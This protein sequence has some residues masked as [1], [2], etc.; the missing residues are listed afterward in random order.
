MQLYKSIKEFKMTT[1]NWFHF[2]A[3]IFFFSFVLSG[4]TALAQTQKHY[5]NAKTPKGLREIFHYTGD[6]VP[7]LSSHRGGPEKNMPEN[8]TATFAN[9]LRY[10][11][12]TMEI[13]PRYTKDSVIIVHHDPT[14]DRTTTGHGKVSDFTYKELQ[15]LNLKDKEGNPTNYKIQTLREMLKWAKGKTILVLDKKD[16]PIEDRIKMVEDCKAESNAIVMA[17]NL[18]EAKLA[19]ELDKDIMM[20]V[21]INTPEKVLEFDQTG[22]P[23]KNVVVFVSHQMPEDTTVFDLIHQKGA[24]CILG[25]SRNL[26]R[27][28]IRGNVSDTGEIKNEYN[29]LFQAGADI[30]ETDIPVEV[31]NLVFDDVPIQPSKKKYFKISK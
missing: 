24:L 23:W 19:Y 6:R 26:D 17:Y 14:L 18:D 22:V 4:I 9:T 5:I 8:H 13:D 28:F 3:V 7:F 10:T 11:W 15:L 1:R 21:F 27:E 31:C 12:S 2:V 30:L 20:Q 29:A 25:T 16:V